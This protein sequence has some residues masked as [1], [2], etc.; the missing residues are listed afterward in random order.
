M[1][2]QQ[3]ILLIL[4]VIIIGIALTVGLLLFTSGNVQA[5][6]DAMVNDINDL[7]ENAFQFRI[8]PRC[9]GGGGCGTYAGWTIP[10]KRKS[11][12]N[13]TYSSS[14]GGPSGVIISG[15]SADDSSNT[16]KA[17]VGTNGKVSSMTF[18]GDFQ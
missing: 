1:G 11:N 7:A 3:I 13:G 12:E 14:G 17:I 15:K 6:K 5:N 2:Q 10:N 4:G 8:R 9:L 18:G 16:I